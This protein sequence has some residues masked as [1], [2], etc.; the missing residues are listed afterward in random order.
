MF[1]YVKTVIINLY[2]DNSWAV[3]VCCSFCYV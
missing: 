3:T 2:K 1:A